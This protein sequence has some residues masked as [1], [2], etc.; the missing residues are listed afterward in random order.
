M[1]PQS[2]FRAN[3]LE[4]S[5]KLEFFIKRMKSRKFI[6]SLIYDEKLRSDPTYEKF[7]KN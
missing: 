6:E 1:Y 3:P 4:N 7:F 2:P 5:S